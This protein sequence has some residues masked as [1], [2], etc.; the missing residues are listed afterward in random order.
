MIIILVGQVICEVLMKVMFLIP[1]WRSGGPTKIVMP[2]LSF[3][4]NPH[5]DICDAIKQ[6]ESEVEK[7][8]FLF[9][10]IFYW[11]SIQT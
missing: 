5:Q 7:I 3:S 4:D 8:H 2:Y 9:F 1:K 10:S 11:G 6:N